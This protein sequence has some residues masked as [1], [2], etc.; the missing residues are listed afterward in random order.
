MVRDFA[1]TPDPFGA[2]AGS[3]LVRVRNPGDGR[4]DQIVISY[5]EIVGWA[6]ITPDQAVKLAEDLLRSSRIMRFEG[7]GR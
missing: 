6:E 3:A 4:H 2:R 5:K 1:R 7:R